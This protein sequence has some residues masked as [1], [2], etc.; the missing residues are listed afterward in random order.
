[1]KYFSFIKKISDVLSKKCNKHIVNGFDMGIPLNIIQTT[2]VNLHYGENVITNKLILLQFLIGF[3]TYSKDRYYDALEWED[4]KFET[5]KQELFEFLIKYKYEYKIAYNIS[6]IAINLLILSELNSTIEIIPF[7][8]FLFLTEYYKDIKRIHPLIKPS[9][10]AIMWSFCCSILPCVLHDKDYS[11]LNYPLDYLPI[12]LTLF[13]NS[14]G[15]DIRDIKED[16]FNGVKTIPVNYGLLNSQT[17]SLLF[18]SLSCLI[19]GLNKHYI[20]FP[21]V[22]SIWELQNIGIAYYIFN[23]NNTII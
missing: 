23:F 20:D 8:F 2:F 16:M 18:L 14:N 11:I 10:I 9:Y 19:F 3:Y 5:D 7:A 6:F 21:I 12:A 15:L 22:N 4:D 13:A 17:I 1:M